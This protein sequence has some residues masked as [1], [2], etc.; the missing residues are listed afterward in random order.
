M[1]VSKGTIGLRLRA[2]ETLTCS[3]TNTLENNCR[4]DRGIQLLFRTLAKKNVMRFGN[5]PL[6]S[7]TCLAV[8][9]ALFERT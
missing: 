1:S 6:R 3:L 9:Q 5:R 7:R 4:N 2:S 8:A